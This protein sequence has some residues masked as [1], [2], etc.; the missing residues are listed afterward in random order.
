MIRRVVLF[1]GVCVFCFSA[2]TL[3]LRRSV[4]GSV[5]VCTLQSGVGKRLAAVAHI[6]AEDLDTIVVIREDGTVLTKSDAVLDLYQ[7]IGGWWHLCRLVGIVPKFIRDLCYSAFG[8]FRYRLFGF[9]QQCVGPDITHSG[10][11][12]SESDLDYWSGI[13]LSSR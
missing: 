12:L 13:L 2:V 3:A 7:S 8:R 10:D 1:D 9:Y 11:W 4:E 6:S 5:K